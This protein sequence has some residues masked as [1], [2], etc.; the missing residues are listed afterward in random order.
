MDRMDGWGR[1]MRDSG[2][3][4]QVGEGQQEASGGGGRAA[5]RA[6]RAL[7]QQHGG[8]RPRHSLIARSQVVL[9]PVEERPIGVVDPAAR[10]GVQVERGG[11]HLVRESFGEVGF[12]QHARAQGAAAAKKVRHQN[13]GA[14]LHV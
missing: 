5:Q 8:G 3:L 4:G 7:H 2:R 14:S 6:A 13:A 1:M 9:A 10:L 12:S 11:R